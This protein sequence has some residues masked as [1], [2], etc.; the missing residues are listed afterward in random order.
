MHPSAKFA[1][2]LSCCLAF[3]T[4]R[5]GTLQCCYYCHKGA[6]APDDLG[7]SIKQDAPHHAGTC[8]GNKRLTML[9]MCHPCHTTTALANA[10]HGNGGTNAVAN[11]TW[12]SSRLA[13]MGGC[14]SWGRGGGKALVG[15]AWSNRSLVHLLARQRSTTMTYSKTESFCMLKRLL[16]MLWP[17]I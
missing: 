4:A 13:S 7:S 9:V 14:R 16:N 10:C 1:W 2:L 8:K 17:R 12:S 3:S 15:G 5:S 6:C 11:P